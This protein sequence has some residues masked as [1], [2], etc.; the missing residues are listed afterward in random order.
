MVP[1]G[2][3]ESEAH[4]ALLARLGALE[5]AGYSGGALAG[6]SLVASAEAAE[7]EV[8]SPGG[9]DYYDQASSGGESY[10]TGTDPEDGP[11]ATVEGHF[12]S[13]PEATAAARALGSVRQQGKRRAAG[14]AGVALGSAS[15]GNAVPRPT[16]TAA[17]ARWSVADYVAA[18]PGGAGR[19]NGDGAALLLRQQA[20]EQR[21]R[22]QRMSQRTSFLPEILEPLRFWASSGSDD[23]AHEAYEAERRDQRELAME[24]A[25]AF[26]AERQHIL[27]E[28]EMTGFPQHGGTFEQ[29]IKEQRRK[30]VAQKIANS[31]RDGGRGMFAI[32]SRRCLLTERRS[33]RFVFQEATIVVDRNAGTICDV[34][35]PHEIT[36]LPDGCE[37]EDVGDSVVMPGLI[38][39]HVHLCAGRKGWEGFASGTQAAAAG[40]ITTVV[41]MPSRCTPLVAD[42]AALER[43]MKSAEGNLWADCGFYGGVGPQNVGQVENMLKGGA[44]GIVCFFT[45][46]EPGAFSTPTD[47]EALCDLLKLMSEVQRTRYAP[48]LVFAELYSEQLLDIAS[49]LRL[50]DPEERARCEFSQLARLSHM[51]G[52]A[53]SLTSGSV[54]SSSPTNSDLF[55]DGGSS[56]I[57]DPGTGR[58]SGGRNSGGMTAA[59]LAAAA[60]RGDVNDTVF[61]DEEDEEDEDNLQAMLARE[62]QRSP[63]PLVT[64]I[65]RRTHRARQKSNYNPR[66]KA[67]FANQSLF[68]QLMKA[69]YGH[70]KLRAGMAAPSPQQRAASQPPPGAQPRERHR[71]TTVTAIG[72]RAQPLP[73]IRS[74]RRGQSVLALRGV[75]LEGGGDAGGHGAGMKLSV[76]SSRIRHPGSGAGMEPPS[77]GGAAA[78]QRRRT[79][80]AVAALGTQRLPLRE[81]LRGAV[82]AVEPLS[83]TP[84]RASSRAVGVGG[85]SPAPSRAPSSGPSRSSPLRGPVTHIGSAPHDSK[86][87]Q[88]SPLGGGV[89]RRGVVSPSPLSLPRTSS[90]GSSPPVVMSLAIATGARA[91]D[92]SSMKVA[93]STSSSGTRSATSS[94]SVSGGSSRRRRATG[95]SATD[96]SSSS[97]SSSSSAGAKS[98]APGEQPRRPPSA[99]E[100]FARM[101]QKEAEDSGSDAGS[102]RGSDSRRAS[103]SAVSGGGR[104]S[105]RASAG[106]IDALQV[107]RHSK[108]E[109]ERLADLRL[110]RA[111]LSMAAAPSLKIDAAFKDTDKLTRRTLLGNYSVFLEQV[112]CVW[113]LRRSVLRC[114]QLCARLTTAALYLHL[115]LAPA[116][117]RGVRGG[118]YRNAAGGDEGRWQRDA[119]SARRGPQGCGGALEPGAMRV[120]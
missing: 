29:D 52:R 89:H 70:P 12:D 42:A 78:T 31:A 77:P 56:F 7:N 71:R 13:D 72:S 16:A 74:E 61:E 6:G 91:A 107:H 83:P 117:S 119:A 20:E 18:L 81:A 46:P 36:L 60:L 2:E 10:F 63:S 14:R 22:E 27:K 88:L 66:K 57:S 84:R 41:D 93:T 64:P 58:M 34:L 28:V 73:T 44:M 104:R 19:S 76:P 113:C 38:D 47:R 120:A 67:S 115:F 105:G 100:R 21:R 92:G 15:E 35:A 94:P 8:S 98:T 55:S 3:V 43:K 26:V 9:D 69:E 54:R 114:C 108:G 95:S 80:P 82:D 50:V 23:E 106:N 65:G 103:A 49:P 24:V 118:R 51:S 110:R 4:A 30:M 25:E 37:L 62:S 39:P 1:A 59:R 97:S 85:L 101:L 68:N 96:S 90:S 11:G 53:P 102:D 40:G 75:G 5:I 109:S 33:G 45:A 17:S 86:L 99:R 79:A 48:L 116:A 87:V 112:R 32:H 111:G